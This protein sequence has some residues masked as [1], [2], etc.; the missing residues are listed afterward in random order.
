MYVYLSEE[1]RRLKKLNEIPPEIK[2]DKDVEGGGG[3]VPFVFEDENDDGEE[4][5]PEQPIERTYFNYSGIFGG[6]SEEEEEKLD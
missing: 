2:L 5:C 3:D 4:K 1:A 6:S